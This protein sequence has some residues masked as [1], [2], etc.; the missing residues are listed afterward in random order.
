MRTGSIAKALV[1]DGDG[2][3][4]VLTIGEHTKYPQLSYAYDLPGGIIEQG[5]TPYDGII[6]EVTEET[7][8]DCT[9]AEIH[10]L[11]TSTELFSEY[12]Y[13]LTRSL[14]LI[15]LAETVEVTLSYEHEAYKWTLPDELWQVDFTGMYFDGFIEH[16][17]YKIRLERLLDA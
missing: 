3:V 12:G 16:A 11:Y 2:K 7:G 4:L 8:I 1:V 9:Q 5:E 17:F 6:R 15:R 13:E 10:E 14:Y